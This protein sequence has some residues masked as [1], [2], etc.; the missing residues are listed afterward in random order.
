MFSKCLFSVKSEVVLAVGY[1]IKYSEITLNN[2][3]FTSDG[4]RTRLFLIFTVF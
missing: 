3:V 2:I 1:R 4:G